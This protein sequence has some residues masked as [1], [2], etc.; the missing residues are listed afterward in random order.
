MFDLKRARSETPGVEHCIHLNNCGAGL[1]PQTVLD[2]MVEYLTLES[3]IG[4]YEAAEQRHDD[5]EHAYAAISRLL[6]C[7][8]REVAIIENATRAWD[9]V[10]YAFNFRP[11][12]RILT[13]VAEYASNFIALLQLKKRFG[14]VIDVVP[15]DESGQFD[16]NQLE[17]MIDPT[18]KLVCV[19]HVPTNGGL[20]NPIVD[21]GKV[22]RSNSIPFMVDACQSVGQIDIDVEVANIDFLSAS[23]RKYLRGPRGVGFLYVAEEWIDR[24]EPPFLDLHA[25]RWITR[26]GFSLRDDARRF[27]NWETNFA[28]KVATGVAVDYALEWGINNINRRIVQLASCARSGLSS[29]PGITVRDKGTHQSGIVSFSCDSAEP[30]SIVSSLKADGINI[31]RSTAFSTR[32]DMDDR[33]LPEVVRAGF[34]YYNSEQEVERFLSAIE[35]LSGEST[36]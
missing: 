27:E 30:V 28:G 2:T 7:Q 9:M 23:T 32:L 12:D 4:G 34:H 21:I 6:N 8:P 13:S 1:M 29:I 35:K 18:V 19:T 15:D 10:V 26:E 3:Q 24:L 11:G 16:V 22:T 36:H 25:A 20:I 14:V 33:N 5:L 31:S 17:N